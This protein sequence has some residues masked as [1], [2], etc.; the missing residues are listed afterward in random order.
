[1][2]GERLK[3]VHGAI[4]GPRAVWFWAR[5]LEIFISL[6]NRSTSPASVKVILDGN[7]KF[8]TLLF[9]VHLLYDMIFWSLTRD[10][11]WNS[12]GLVLSCL[13]LQNSLFPLKVALRV[14]SGLPTV[15]AAKRKRF[16][17]EALFL[18]RDAG[19]RTPMWVL[20]DS[21]CVIKLLARQEM[22]HEAI[23]GPDP[24]QLGPVASNPY[25]NDMVAS[26]DS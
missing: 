10:Y 16:G 5:A 11:T 20:L 22:V 23:F 26:V 14:L 3:E 13:Q 24:V 17:T 19:G 12:T 25:M 1:M 6:P 2:M 7:K 8:C 15:V 4:F 18:E 9:E 21:C